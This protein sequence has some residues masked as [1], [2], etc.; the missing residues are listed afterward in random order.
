MIQSILKYG[1]IFIGLIVLQVLVVNNITL[2]YLVHPYVYFMLIL[3]LPVS[4]SNSLLLVIGFFTGIVMDMFAATP[5]LHASAC[6]F[7]AFVRPLTV[8]MFRPRSINEED[9]DPHIHSFGFGNFVLYALVLTFLH[10]LFLHI[11]EV[12]EFVEF[13]RTLFRVVLNTLASLGL[14]LVI[15]LLILVR[16]QAGS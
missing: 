9:T 12:F 7:I 1:L 16:N 2:F 15:E 13:E 10:H 14:L 6:V 3:L 8:R 11:V 4:I 5:G